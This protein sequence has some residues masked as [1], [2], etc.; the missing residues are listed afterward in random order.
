[1]RNTVRETL[2]VAA[3]L[4]LSGCVE[5]PAP[6]PAEVRAQI[7]EVNRR[8]G[9]AVLR[10]D[11]EALAGFYASDALLL[12]PA[13]DILAGD[14][15][16]GKFWRE[17]VQSGVNGLEIS[18]LEVDA[19]GDK[20]I[21]VGTYVLKNAAGTPVDNGKYIVVWKRVDGAWR[22]HR[23]IFNSSVPPPAGSLPAERP[24]E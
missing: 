5:S 7:A 23:D 13:S 12:P 10:G 22:L 9:E 3:I 8:I 17:A 18:T 2:A 14:E 1:M 16:I 4:A 19:A 15:A 21:E 24:D 20:A 11:A 6:E